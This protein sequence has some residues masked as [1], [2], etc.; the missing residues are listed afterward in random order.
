MND[1]PTSST[2]SNSAHDAASGSA[3]E[4]AAPR[5]VE[6][7]CGLFRR[8]RRVALL[9]GVGLTVAAFVAAGLI[10]RPKPWRKDRA[11]P[12]NSFPLTALSSS[13]FLNTRSD[14]EYVGSD[15]CG[16]CH[17]GQAES[18]RQTGMGRSMTEIDAENEPA[19]AAFDHPL[20]NRRYQVH[21]AAGQ[22]WHRELLRAAQ[23]DEVVLSDYPLKYVVG[24]GHHSRTYLAEVDGFLVESPVTWYTARD[25][26]G[27]SPGYDTPQQPGFE[28]AAGEGCLNCHSGRAYAEEKSLH[29]M[30]VLEPAIGCERCHGP[31][32]L[33][34]ER[35]EDMKRDVAGRSEAIDETIVN[36]THLSP[37]LAEAIC[38]QCHLRS[39][40]TVVARGRSVSDFRPGLPLEDFRHDYNFDATETPMTVVG[41]VEQLHLSRCYQASDALSCLTCHDPHAEPR[42]DERVAY[43]VSVCVSC[44]E[45]DRCTVDKA[46][47]SELS[48]ENNC[49]EC[50]MPRSA[51]EIPHLAFTHHRIGV[52]G[53]ARDAAREHVPASYGAALL[54]PFR[55]SARFGDVDQ[56]RALGLGYLEAGNRET[57]AARAASLRHR[58]LELLSEARAAGL[59]DAVLEASLARIRFDLRL[60]D[61]QTY[62]ES[63]L[64]FPDL[65]GQDRCNALFL[66]ADAQAA[67]G[68]KQD[69]VAGLRQLVE[70]RRHSV[71]WLLLADCEQA[72]G[73]DAGTVESLEIA[74][75]I[76]PRLWKAH[77]YLAETYRQQ[78]DAARAAWHQ[79]LAVP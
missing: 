48:P 53:R 23:P 67:A 61:G 4:S 79:R 21:R 32:A 18:Y 74:V 34:I 25:A 75:R 64:A 37:Q 10:G 12:A 22:L 47:R 55:D 29:R 78:G 13:R 62:A 41:H 1:S 20:S 24:S 72:L 77:R 43:Y 52:H 56:K 57:D 50:H 7:A 49:V 63:A 2:P 27:M 42:R 76:N 60:P 17:P 68:R 5:T 70:L 36:P 30:R 8:S 54:R 35:H 46:R 26:W 71:D 28:R 40:A 45:P 6:R 51:T 19:N 73:N 44:H 14:V 33:H 58:A 3:A 15:A 69:A 9:V 31:G 66:L 59:R 11:R 39:T 16:T 65:S 38:Q